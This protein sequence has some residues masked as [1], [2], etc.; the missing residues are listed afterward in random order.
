MSSRLARIVRVRDV[1]CIITIETESGFGNLLN[2]RREVS[3]CL[4]DAM[5]IHKLLPWSQWMQTYTM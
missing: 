5:D 3:I 2:V 4:E 1:D